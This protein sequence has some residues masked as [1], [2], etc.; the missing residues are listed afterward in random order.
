MADEAHP[1]YY[2]QYSQIMT[3]EGEQ[4]TY[5]VLMLTPTLC[6]HNY[7]VHVVETFYISHLE[8]KLLQTRGVHIVGLCCCSGRVC[9]QQHMGDILVTTQIT[10]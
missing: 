7:T 6:L 1:G 5:T 3:G 9:E 8:G 2:T 10:K 4:P